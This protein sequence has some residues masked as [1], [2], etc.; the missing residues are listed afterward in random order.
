[1]RAAAWLHSRRASAAQRETL[2]A[3]YRGAGDMYY[4]RIGRYLVGLSSRDDILAFARTPQIQ[5]EVFYYLGLMAQTDGRI[6]DAARWYEM[7]LETGMPNNSEYRWA[8]D[9]LTLWTSRPYG[10]SR[11]E[12][13]E[14][15]V[16][17]AVLADANW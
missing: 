15:R 13:M 14:K 12:A 3:H 7:V 17:E 9:Q 1:M 10:L 2:L 6:V 5:C 11:F 8:A 16:P 4:H